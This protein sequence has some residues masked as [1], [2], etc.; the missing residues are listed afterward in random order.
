VPVSVY[1]RKHHSRRCSSLQLRSSKYHHRRVPSLPT[2]L[3]L[4][5]FL[6]SFRMWFFLLLLPL[7]QIT[8]SFLHHKSFLPAPSSRTITN[9]FSF[10]MCFFFSFSFSFSLSLSQRSQLLFF[11]TN[12]FLH[13]F[14]SYNHKHLC[15]KKLNDF[16]PI[17]FSLRSPFLVLCSSPL[18]LNHHHF[19]SHVSHS[20]AFVQSSLSL[21]MLCVSYVCFFLRT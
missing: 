2:V 8:T 7:P 9:N 18:S 5:T 1:L 13:H 15:T 21:L 16:F 14:F 3:Q 6:L 20:V 10:R 4:C 19:L 12:P 17:V 11:I